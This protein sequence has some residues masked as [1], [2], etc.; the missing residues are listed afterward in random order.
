[1]AFRLDGT[2][3]LGLIRL[4]ILLTGFLGNLDG[5]IAAQSPLYSILNLVGSGILGVYAY[6]KESWV[7]LPLEIIWAAAAA[8]SLVKQ[9]RSR[10]RVRNSRR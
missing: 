3:A 8:A 6:L 7:F 2:D 1:M 10:A 4:L 9:T 5:K